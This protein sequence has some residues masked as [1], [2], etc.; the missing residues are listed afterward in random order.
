MR[1]PQTRWIA[2]LLPE[3]A[4]PLDALLEQS[5]GLD[6]WERHPDYWVVAADEEQLAEIERRRLAQVQRRQTV[7]DYLAASGPAPAS[8]DGERECHE[9][10]C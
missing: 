10:D 1:P 2:H 9:P 6:V 5:L 8:M 4:V 3:R 7:S